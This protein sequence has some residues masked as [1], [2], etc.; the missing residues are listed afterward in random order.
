MLQTVS[1]ELEL[2]LKCVAEQWK[3]L[4][5]IYYTAADDEGAKYIMIRHAATKRI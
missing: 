4:W 2:H 1:Q 3:L 5:K